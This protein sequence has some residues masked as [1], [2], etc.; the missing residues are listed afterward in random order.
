MINLISI[1]L[2]FIKLGFC[3]PETSYLLYSKN[4]STLKK[5]FKLPHQ[6]I[7]GNSA[8]FSRRLNQ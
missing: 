6:Q 3:P 8:P 7:L 1:H 4:I 2:N 5:Y